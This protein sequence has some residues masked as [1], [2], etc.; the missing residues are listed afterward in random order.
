MQSRRTLLLMGGTAVKP[1][2]GWD[3]YIMMPSG[4][5]LQAHENTK[6]CI[7]HLKCLV[8]NSCESSSGIAQ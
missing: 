3:M 5:V 4:I 2:G 6:L 1:F 8:A 7:S